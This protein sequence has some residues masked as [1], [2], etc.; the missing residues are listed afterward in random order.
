MQSQQLV[1]GLVTFLHDLFTVIWVGGLVSLG[2]IVLPTLLRLYG[3]GPETRRVMEAIQKRLSPWVY[4]SIV[5]LVVTGILLGQRNPAFEGMFS[6]SNA[7]STTMA[8]KHLLVLA[9]IAIAVLRSRGLGAVGGLKTE[10]R[11]KLKGALLYLNMALGILVL[12]LSG[13]GAA[14]GSAPRPPLG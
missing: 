13:L 5:G 6:F 3:R 12:L 11:E 8:I 10:K 9:M 2:G 1:F 4:G 14:L 7:Y